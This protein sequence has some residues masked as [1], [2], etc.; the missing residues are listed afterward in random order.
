MRKTLFMPL[1][2]ICFIHLSADFSAKLVSGQTRPPNRIVRTPAKPINPVQPALPK[3]ILPS[4]DMLTMIRRKNSLDVGIST[5]TPWAM[6]DKN[7]ELIGF[8]VEVAKKLASDLGVKLNLMPVG[9]SEIIGDLTNNRF[10]IIVT[11]I[12]PTPQR[13][14]FVNFSEPYSE[15]KIELVA[16]RDK[17]RNKNDFKDY[18]KS[19][20]TIGIVSGTVYA[21]YIKDNF[22]QAKTQNFTDEA[23]L[24]QAVASGR[25]EAGIAST[26]A[27]EFAVRLHKDKLYRPFNEPLGKLGES[28]AIR[29]GDTDFLNYLNT[30]IRYYEQ[31]GWLNQQR[32]KWF[33]SDA[34]LN[35]L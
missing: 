28:F 5:F 25:I 2:L 13:A 8:E 26:P 3:P 15:S 27:P 1:L 34:W 4:D 6:H 32:K 12:Y 31:T 21:D 30:W 22:P 19:D 17:M 10:D 23:E 29:R 33:E 9:F 11:G 20:V 35:Q 14:L 16:S 7:G 18:N 24:F